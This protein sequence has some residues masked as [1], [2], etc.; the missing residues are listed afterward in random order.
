MTGLRIGRR[1][2]TYRTSLRGLLAL[3]LS[4]CGASEAKPHTQAAAAST[5]WPLADKQ[6]RVE[7]GT[8]S[9]EAAPD[10][11]LLA[12]EHEIGRVFP[13]LSTQPTPVYF[14]S[15]Q[16]T[17]EASYSLAASDSA[18]LYSRH[19]KQRSLDVDLRIGSAARDQTHR[20]PGEAT[21]STFRGLRL[22][23]LD[24]EGPALQ[25][26]LWLA[27]D[28]EYELARQQWM[29]VLASEQ[30][31]TKEGARNGDFSA[32]PKVTSLGPPAEFDLNTTLWRDRLRK[33]SSLAREYPDVMNSSVSLDVVAQTRT[34]ASSEGSRVQRGRLQVRLSVEASTLSSDGMPLARFD[35]LDLAS[36]DKLPDDEELRVRFARVLQDVRALRD[37]P[38]I[39]PYAGPAILDGRAA[40]VFFHEIFG[41]R[42]E[43][44]RQD[45]DTEGQTFASLVGKQVLSTNLSIYDD[46]RL[47][48]IGGVDL[49]GYYDYDDEGVPAMRAELVQDGVLRGFLMSRAPARSFVRSNGHGRR[50]QGH[51]V[52]ARQANLVVEPDSVV[53]PETL[54]KALLAEVKRQGLPYGLRFS[55]ITGGFTQTARSDTQ[56]FKVMPVMVYRVYPDGTEE[57]V[58]GVDMEGTPLTSLSKILLA[59]NDFQT[60]NGVCGAES[61][62]VPV[63]ATSPSLLISQIEVAR[64]EQTELRPPVLPW[65]ALGAGGTP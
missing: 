39:E 65:P 54:K 9:A 29:R 48:R 55:E 57:L 52:V 19:D 6:L 22:L 36:L 26:A 15:Y 17:D 18:E 61:G 34:F 62:W 58:R 11:L 43:G 59:A 51:G 24:G 25:D 49:N 44:H 16:V 8:K 63:S 56:A 41:H 2:M 35:T 20:I 10:A 23:P 3:L 40:G 31:S 4:A 21:D 45:D 37:A 28:D 47:T 46:P 12:L 33:I 50:Q 42:I 64:Q 13:V 38:L 60:F 27:T 32:E 5:Q 14:L 53:T 7:L 1:R 30:R